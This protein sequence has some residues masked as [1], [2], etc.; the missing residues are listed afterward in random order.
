MVKPKKTKKQIAVKKKTS[1]SKPPKTVSKKKRAKTYHL[2]PEHIEFICWEIALW[3]GD[4]VTVNCMDKF[5]N[6]PP[7]GTKQKHAHWWKDCIYRYFQRDKFEMPTKE[8]KYK[9]KILALRKEY[10]SSIKD[11]VPLSHA[12]ERLKKL[13]Q[14]LEY[15]LE[16]RISRYQTIKQIKYKSIPSKKDKNGI[17]TYKNVGVTKIIP[18]PVKER[19]LDVARKTLETIRAE[20]GD[21]KIDPNAIPPEDITI[22]RTVIDTDNSKYKIKLPGKKKDAD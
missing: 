15:A 18:I 19:K 7:G 3:R 2:L 22:R 17:V 16:E 21:D 9:Q 8:C 14:I 1:S 20:V 13:E 12:R 6:Y 5:P 4:L 10:L 11:S